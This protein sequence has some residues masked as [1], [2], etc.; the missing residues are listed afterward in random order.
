MS[1]DRSRERESTAVLDL[2]RSLWVRECYS[3]NAPARPL[4]PDSL[5][6]AAIET[7]A[8]DRVELAAALAVL[9]TSTT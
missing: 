4:R 9:S 5:F 1:E 6:A 7:V 8:R 3:S 2:A